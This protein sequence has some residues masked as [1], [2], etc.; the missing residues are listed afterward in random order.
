MLKQRNDQGLD[1]GLF[2]S[3]ST[4]L[5]FAGTAPYGVTVGLKLH[6]LFLRN[7]VQVVGGLAGMA[8]PSPIPPLSLGHEL[9]DREYISPGVYRLH[10]SQR[11]HQIMYASC[12]ICPV[13]MSSP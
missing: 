5:K 9:S 3:Q 8:P 10:G 1:N 13:N 4:M 6:H 11:H 12:R 7:I 2:F